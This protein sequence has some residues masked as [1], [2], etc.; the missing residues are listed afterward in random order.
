MADIR[1]FRK[2]IEDLS[3]NDYLK[4]K[5]A[6]LEKKNSRLERD[7]RELREDVKLLKKYKDSPLPRK[8]GRKPRPMIQVIEDEMSRAEDQT[9]KVTDIIAMLKKKNVK[10]KAQNMY[11]SV[12]A[13]L[14]HSDKFEKVAPGEF[15]LVGGSKPAKKKKTSKKAKKKKK[16]TAKK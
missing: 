7:I 8:K 4:K 11:S 10:S 6:A 9:M 14:T 3:G 13:S 5:V 1:S 16:K 15:K 12:A 2:Y